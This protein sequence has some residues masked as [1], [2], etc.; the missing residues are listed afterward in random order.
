[1]LEGRYPEQPSIKLNVNVPVLST[2]TV[3][4]SWIFDK[5]RFD[6]DFSSSELVSNFLKTG[7][8]ENE[9]LLLEV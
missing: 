4:L 5:Y 3:N 1:L 2:T 6:N 9:L 8:P 7:I